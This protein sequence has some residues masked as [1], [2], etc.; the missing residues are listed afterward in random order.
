M[1]TIIN[2]V[3]VT[4]KGCTSPQGRSLCRSVEETILERVRSSQDL[5]NYKKA[6]RK[7]LVWVEPLF[8]E[9]KD[10][11]GMRRFRLRRLWRV[12]SEALLRAAGQNLK[13]LLKK[14]G[15]GRRPFPTEAQ[16][17]MPP[18]SEEAEPFPRSAL[19]NNQGA[20]IAVA[21]VASASVARTFLETLTSLF[22]LINSVSDAYSLYT[23]ISSF[24]VFNLYSF[25]Y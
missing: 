24:Y 5:E 21:S 20:S 14:R 17:L 16:A 12:N 2:P 18:A 10:W 19:L 3:R 1:D 13:R 8:A 15:W 9:G 22:S 23:V 4:V 6:L 25:D 11:H 7:R